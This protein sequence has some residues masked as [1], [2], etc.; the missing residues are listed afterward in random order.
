MPARGR[1]GLKAEQPE[2]ERARR[3]A[4][5]GKPHG[6]CEGGD[7]AARSTRPHGTAA[8]LR[9]LWH[10]QDPKA[11]VPSLVLAVPR[12]FPPTT[13]HC[14]LGSTVAQYKVPMREAP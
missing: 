8:T 11:L 7:G 2:Q 10:C 9:T 13:E 1:E 12:V 14:A 4:G 3:Q 5:Y 6:G